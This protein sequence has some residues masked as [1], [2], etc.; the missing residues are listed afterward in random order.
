MNFWS[1]HSLFFCVLM[2]FF[3]RFT[4]LAATPW[5]GLFWWVGLIFAP[6]VTVAILAL[7]YYGSTNFILCGFVWWWAIRG[8]IKEK[9]WIRF[10]YNVKDMKA[11][12]VKPLIKRGA[13]G[14]TYYSSKRSP[15]YDERVV[16]VEAKVKK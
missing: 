16:D 6:R 4:M 15:R 5:G 13:G 8:E 1:V 14:T 9:R 11:R 3:P 7:L 10:F 2:Y 12:I